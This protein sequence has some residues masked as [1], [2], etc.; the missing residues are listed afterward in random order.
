MQTK[1]Y[2]IFRNVRT[3]A[4]VISDNKLNTLMP[5]SYKYINTAQKYILYELPK[6]YALKHAM[7]QSF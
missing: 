4:G 1:I 2:F 7:L 3:G 5:I 6:Y